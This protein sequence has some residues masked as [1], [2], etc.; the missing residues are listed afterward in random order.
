MY[1]TSLSCNT[2][3]DVFVRKEQSQWQRIRITTTGKT[4]LV[5]VRA[6]PV[7]EASPK[8][9]QKAAMQRHRNPA[10]TATARTNAAKTEY[11]L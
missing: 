1:K 5:R 7:P 11:S 6:V 9:L 3:G 4:P 8:H 10:A 2:K